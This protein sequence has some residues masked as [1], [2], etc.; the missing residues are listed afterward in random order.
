MNELK[1]ETTHNERSVPG[2]SRKESK[3]P[4][5][6]LSRGAHSLTDV[7]NNKN[8][9]AMKID[10]NNDLSKDNTVGSSIKVDEISANVER[11]AEEKEAAT[12][13]PLNIIPNKFKFNDNN[14]LKG[15]SVDSR[16]FSVRHPVSLLFSQL[17]R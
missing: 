17:L 4:G 14:A 11:I 1:K 7:Q 9:T 12:L 8:S 6:N 10:N 15:E 2:D 13:F 3:I 16:G 5:D